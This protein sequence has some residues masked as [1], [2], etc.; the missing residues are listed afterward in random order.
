M[1]RTKDPTLISTVFPP[2]FVHTILY[3]M[4]QILSFLTFDSNKCWFIPTA[5]EEVPPVE[6][7]VTPEEPVKAPEEPAVPATEPAVAAET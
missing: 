4:L 6:Q 7:S 2:D 1:V 3:S 5:A